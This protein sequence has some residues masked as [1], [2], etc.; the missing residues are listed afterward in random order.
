[1][2]SPAAYSPR[3]TFLG[4]SPAAR[5]KVRTFPP[6]PHQHRV[7]LLP[8][9]GLQNDL[10]D[11]QRRAALA[12]VR[13]ADDPVVAGAAQVLPRLRLRQAEGAQAIAV[14]DDPEGAQRRT[15]PPVLRVIDRNAPDRRRNAAEDFLRQLEGLEHALLRQADIRLPPAA[16]EDV[17][18]D[19]IR[20]HGELIA[21]E[22]LIA[23]R[24]AAVLPL[25][26]RPL[27]V[28]A[29]VPLDERALELLLDRPRVRRDDDHLALVG[30][31]GDGAHRRLEREE[32][33]QHR[34][35]GCDQNKS[36]NESAH[37]SLLCGRL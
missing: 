5:V 11:G 7:A 2:A 4:I 21:N 37:R 9:V 27:A 14:V 30:V 23:A 28:S 1:M 25:D 33:A 29:L 3:A 36:G 31:G 15:V 19:A 22:A 20:R 34:R 26:G 16:P 8:T 12:R 13:R 32:R 24:A 18:A 35:D 6:R 17:D 10:D